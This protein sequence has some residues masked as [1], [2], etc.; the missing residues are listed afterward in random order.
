MKLLRRADDDAIPRTGLNPPHRNAEG[1]EPRRST[2][3]DRLRAS[4]HVEH[5][6][7]LC[8]G[9]VGNSLGKQH[10][11]GRIDAL[12]N[13]LSIVFLAEVNRTVRASENGAAVRGE[14][15]DI[16]DTRILYRDGARGKH[17]LGELAHSPHAPGVD[18]MFNL[19]IFD[20]ARG[21]GC[22]PPRLQ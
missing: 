21:R 19:R 18:Q 3:N 4:A 12:L 5:Q 11:I 7:E 22:S 8:A 1:F 14:R 6:A 2:A 15:L 10:W 16:I 13:N 9:D 17:D 20:R